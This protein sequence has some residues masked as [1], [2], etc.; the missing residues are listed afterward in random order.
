MSCSLLHR[1][2]R[3]FFYIYLYCFF[4]NIV[5]FMF[6]TGYWLVRGSLSAAAVVFHSTS[7]VSHHWVAAHLSTLGVPHAE[8]T[9]ANG[10][11]TIHITHARWMSY[12][13]T[14]HDERPH[15]MC[16]EWVW[17]LS[18]FS[19]R[20]LI[21][22]VQHAEE[23]ESDRQMITT[24]SHQF[25]D[26]LVRLCLHAGY[27]ASFHRSAAEA[28]APVRWCVSYTEEEQYSTPLLH[29][30]RD[31]QVHSVSEGV[32]VWCVTVP[33]HNLIVVRRTAK[34]KQGVVTKASRPIV[35]GNC[36]KHNICHRDL[37]PVRQTTHNKAHSF[38]CTTT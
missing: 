9:E 24:S 28:A 14:Q 37:K 20:L 34:D 22:G 23:C 32:L 15:S 17:K 5:D 38:D 25:R 2:I 21:A 11:N 16:G 31:V 33:P 35:V 36:H 13:S 27:S 26:E 4:F 29:P 12:F 7:F 19:A 18:K 10:S 1:L 3:P 6:I 30:H 8:C